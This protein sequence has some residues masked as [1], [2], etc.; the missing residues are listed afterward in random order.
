MFF[1]F[2]CSINTNQNP[3]K[4][5]VSLIHSATKDSNF[6]YQLYKLNNP[7]QSEDTTNLSIVDFLQARHIGN[8]KEDP[9]ENYKNSVPFSP[10][11]DFRFR[12]KT[13]SK[14]V[15]KLIQQKEPYYE[16]IFLNNILT[17]GYYLLKFLE[18]NIDSGVYTLEVQKD[19]LVINEKVI[20]LK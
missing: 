19:D 8:D 15:I 2:S 13:S 17:S 12:V 16:L 20:Y 5:N 4:V 3:K 10:A 1:V 11:N 9:F 7:N 14:V 6:V 18:F